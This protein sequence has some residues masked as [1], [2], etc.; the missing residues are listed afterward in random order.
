LEKLEVP[1]IL[2]DER[3]ERIFPRFVVGATCTSGLE[4]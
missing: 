4:N 2:S 3:E 1:E